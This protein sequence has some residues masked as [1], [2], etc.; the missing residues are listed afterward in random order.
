MSGRPRQSFGRL[1]TVSEFIGSAIDRTEVI[2]PV[3]TSGGVG[4]PTGGKYLCGMTLLVIANRTNIFNLNFL[5]FEIQFKVLII[6]QIMTG[7]NILTI[8]D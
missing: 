8:V 3:Y 6:K 4:C 1:R 2:V 7:V 5:I